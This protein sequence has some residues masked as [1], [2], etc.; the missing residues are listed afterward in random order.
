MFNPLRFFE[1]N[2]WDERAGNWLRLPPNPKGI[3]HFLGGAFLATAP[4]LSYRSLLDALAEAGYMVVATPFLN[5]F[6]HQAIARDVLNRFENLCT[7]LQTQ[8]RLPPDLPIYGVGH[9]MGSKIHLLIGSLYEVQRAGNVLMAFNNYPVERSIPWAEQLQLREALDLKFTPSPEET[10]KLVGSDY[11]IATNLLIQFRRDE[12][13]QTR[14]LV[15]LLETKF[16]T[17]T[18][19]QVLSGTHLTP[20]SQSVD[21]KAGKVFTPMDAIAQWLKAEI[22]GDLEMLQTQV[23]RWLGEA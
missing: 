19:L 7:R 10:L 6:D 5:T 1:D 12:L 15:P 11:A 18:R 17:A 13:D 9:S 8:D 3:V 21:W 2:P 14:E 16:G 4:H 22:N 23:L 20:I